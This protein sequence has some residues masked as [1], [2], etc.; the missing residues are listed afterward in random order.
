IEFQNVSFA[1]PGATNNALENV[2]F[3]I[4]AGEKV[5]I[6]G[7]NGSGKTTI[8][9]LIL[10]L[11]KPISGSVLIDGIDI[12]QI[13]PVDLR[14]NIGYVPQDVLLLNGTVRENIVYRAPYVDDEVFLRAVKLGGVDD[15]I[16]SHP[17]GA[18]LPVMERGDGISGGQRQSIAIARAFLLDS[19][20]I[21]LDEP[22]NSLDSSSENKI[23]N[24]LK[25]NIEGKTALLVTHKMALLDLVDRLIVIERSH[26][27]LDGSKEDV[28]AKLNG[29][30]R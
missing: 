7:R 21:L 10:G 22:T 1:Y 2:S 26:V 19:P 3:K 5:A 24:L 17:L 15:F 29:V 25:S 4:E 13:D 28:L 6:L 27:L 14:K 11:Y 30:K 9:K 8:E 18:D 12:N 23:K 20:I 16:D